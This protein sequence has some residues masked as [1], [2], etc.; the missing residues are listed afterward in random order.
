[1]SDIHLSPNA[2]KVLEALCRAA[3]R[4][5]AQP[6][7]LTEDEAVQGMMELV[8]NREATFI[9]HPDGRWEFQL[10]DPSKWRRH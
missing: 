2:T 4:S 7:H 9:R 3:A 6:P 1:M 10:T 8:M 5:G